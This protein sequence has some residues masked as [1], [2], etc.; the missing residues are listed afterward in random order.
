MPWKSAGNLMATES[1]LVLNVAVI[2]ADEL[3]LRV[4]RIAADARRAMWVAV[5]F[6]ALAVLV[7]V[8]IALR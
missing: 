4:D 7:M 1:N 3:L 2:D 8:T 5:G 6:W